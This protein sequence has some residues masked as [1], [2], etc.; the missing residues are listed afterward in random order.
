MTRFSDEQALRSLLQKLEGLSADAKISAEAVREAQKALAALGQRSRDAELERLLPGPEHMKA[1]AN[2]AK[3]SPENDVRQASLEFLDAL[4]T[5]LIYRRMR[6]YARVQLEH[7]V[8]AC[9][10]NLHQAQIDPKATSFRVLVMSMQVLFACAIMQGKWIDRVVQEAGNFWQRSINFWMPLPD[11]EWI[12][13]FLDR[14]ILFMSVV[15]KEDFFLSTLQSLLGIG[16]ISYFDPERL[17]EG[18]RYQWKDQDSTSRSLGKFCI[19]I[20]EFVKAACIA[21]LNSQSSVPK[22]ALTDML[23]KAI[24]L[25]ISSLDS[26]KAISVFATIVPAFA[27]SG[28]MYL[29]EMSQYSRTALEPRIVAMR[30]TLLLESSQALRSLEFQRTRV[31]MGIALADVLICSRSSEELK[32]LSERRILAD[33]ETLTMSL[34]EIIG[35]NQQRDEWIY[36]QFALLRE[37]PKLSKAVGVLINACTSE[38]L[39]IMSIQKIL[40]RTKELY[41]SWRVLLDQEHQGSESQS[42]KRIRSNRRLRPM[43]FLPIITLFESTLRVISTSSQVRMLALEILSCIEFSRVKSAHF[44][45]VFEQLTKEPPDDVSN[46]IDRYPEFSG[47]PPS[48]LPVDPIGDHDTPAIGRDYFFLGLL[49]KWAS[50]A[51]EPTISRTIIPVIMR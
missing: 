17:E 29:P 35:V 41:L 31:L 34:F 40:S 21:I 6:R 37:V 51:S 8:S 25:C 50:H 16:R 47:F 2:L 32:D 1:L 42:A 38:E 15:F 33:I 39:L 5:R 9:L 14:I 46:F 19:I 3:S 11:P 24:H 28:F 49:L 13:G 45:P 10:D 44:P 43:T 23:Q 30:D 26:Q 18:S 20:S 36:F 22:T 27:L 4:L 48:P 12:T 7:V